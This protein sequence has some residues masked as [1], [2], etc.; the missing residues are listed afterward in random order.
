MAGQTDGLNWGCR[1]R[2]KKH[3]AGIGNWQIGGIRNTAKE[4]NFFFYLFLPKFF[5][6][7][8]VIY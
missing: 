8:L 4:Q 3:R 5:K 6:S 7:A 2:L 1:G